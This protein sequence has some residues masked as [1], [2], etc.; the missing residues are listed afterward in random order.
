MVVVSRAAHEFTER[1]RSSWTMAWLSVQAPHPCRGKC[2]SPTPVMK[3]RA[4]M[5]KNGQEQWLSAMI[6]IFG[7]GPVATNRLTHEERR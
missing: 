4:S 6:I 3:T 1:V 5:M 2:P 7:A